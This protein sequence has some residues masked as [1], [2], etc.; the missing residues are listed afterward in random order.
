[1][2][3]RRYPVTAARLAQILD[4]SERTIYRDIAEL[5][6]QG[7]PI[8]GE[9]GIGYVLK[10]GHFLPP[11]MLSEEEMEA[12]LLGLRYVDQRGDAVLVEAGASAL[13]KIG[14]VLPPEA[15]AALA[16]PLAVPGPDGYGFPENAVPL[17][18]LRAAIRAGR[19]LDI[20][21]RDAAGRSSRRTVWPIHLGFMDEARVLAAWCTLRRDFRF[22]RT[23]R[24]QSAKV[25]DR[26]PA[27]RADL[28]RDF[29]AQ[30]QENSLLTETGGSED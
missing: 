9:A 25:G 15:R 11:L 24:I 12:V 20:A 27:R 6:A 28:L 13:A 17:T 22:F 10:P 29:R 19:Q 18:E 8:A 7:A 3:G 5:A 21:Y 4:V 2:R 1:M 26:Y 30:Q 23:D 16:T 14:S